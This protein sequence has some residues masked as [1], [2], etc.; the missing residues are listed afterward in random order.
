MRRY[1]S[2]LLHGCQEPW[3]TTPTCFSFRQRITQ[4]PVRRLTVISARTVACYLA[5]RDDPEAALCPH[6]PRRPGKVT[7]KIPTW[8]EQESRPAAVKVEKHT[9]GSCLAGRGEDRG[10]SSGTRD[11]RLPASEPE[12]NS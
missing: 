12:E 1:V 2:Q 9:E 6:Q 3:C 10:G 4:G 11:D 8:Q 7:G 5:T